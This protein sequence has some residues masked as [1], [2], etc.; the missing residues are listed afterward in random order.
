[1]IQTALH[2]YTG[3]GIN[4]LH[5]KIVDVFRIQTWVYGMVDADRGLY[6]KALRVRILPG[7]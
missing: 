5:W 7:N 6:H 2:Y 1:M 4:Q 3:P